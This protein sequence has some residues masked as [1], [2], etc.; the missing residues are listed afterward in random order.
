MKQLLEYFVVCGI[1]PEIR[2]VDGEKGFHGTD[3]FYLASLLDL[4]PPI[5]STH[6][7]P[8]P[9]L[10]TVSFLL[11]VSFISFMCTFCKL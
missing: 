5:T 3:V 4:Y 1:G 10:P 7:P 11:P 2:T 9:Q 6:M 8:P